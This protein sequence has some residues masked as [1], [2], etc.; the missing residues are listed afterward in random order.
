[1][2]DRMFKI[3]ILFVVIAPFVGVLL[4]A[5]LTW[6]RYVFL[7]DLVLALVLHL[8]GLFGITI[9]YHRMLTH[10]SFQSHPFI[11]YFFVLSGCFALEGAP[12]DW[13][14]TH[15]KHHAHSDEEDDPHSPLKSFWH[16]HTGWLF[17]RSNYADPKEYCPH[18]LEEKPLVWI[19]NHYTLW[20]FAT[21]IVPFLIG[22]W[23]GL[24]WGGFVRIFLTTHITWSVNSICHTFGNRDFETT[25]ESRNNWL[26]GLLALGEGWHNNH[27]AF[28]K[29]AFHGM[30][31]YQ[32]D[33]SGMIIR[34]LEKLGLAWDVQRVG[35]QT[36]E[37]QRKRGVSMHENMVELKRELGEFIDSAREELVKKM[38]KLPPKRVAALRLAHETTLHRFSEIQLHLQKRRNMKKAAIERRR[39]EVAQLLEVAKQRMQGA[40][41]V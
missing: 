7:E 32:L 8:I 27:H 4:A 19:N 23:T 33:A 14:A 41:K 11:R 17:D 3:R 37:A 12:L 31:W 34:V 18:L 30:W 25:D 38:R 5:I 39:R 36:L 9:G 28:P 10:S 13:T 24:L 35:Q 21:F 20:A 29:N 16:A 26:I 6:N 2:S 1:M 22:G 40:A 15:V